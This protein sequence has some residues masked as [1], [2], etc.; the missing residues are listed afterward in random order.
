MVI[1]ENNYNKLLQQT[2]KDLELWTKMLFSLLGRIAAIKMSILPK[3]LY[4]FQT[5]P[6]KLEKT[7]F[8]NLNKMTAKFIW[9][10]KKPRIKMKLLQDMKSRGGFG[11]P[12]G[13]IL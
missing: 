9:Q 6:V 12:N 7:F 10:D 4:L 13:I 2:K 8:D 11:L 1:K 3:F 5:I